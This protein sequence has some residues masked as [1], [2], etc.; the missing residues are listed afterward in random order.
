MAL[1]ADILLAAGAAGVAVYCFVLS[2]R[3]TRF[4]D[5]ERGVGGAVAVLSAQV[6]D[7][8]KAMHAARAAADDS[9][10]SLRDLTERAEDVARRLEL[11]LASLHDFEPAAKPE[12]DERPAV[13]ATPPQDAAKI[14]ETSRDEPKLREVPTFRSVSARASRDEAIPAAPKTPSFFARRNAATAK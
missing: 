12:P 7:L 4:T 9:G 6:D 5:L 11:H 8:T 13:P 14:A 1:I 2:R 10:R 3:L